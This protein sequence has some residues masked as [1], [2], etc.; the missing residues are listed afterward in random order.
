[1]LLIFGKDVV[2][3]QPQPVLRVQS[4]KCIVP[5]SQNVN[6]FE[7]NVPINGQ[8]VPTERRVERCKHQGIG[9]IA[10][11]DVVIYQIMYQATAT[12]IGF[13]AAKISLR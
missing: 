13:D 5:C 7:D 9:Y 2:E 6:I 12:A 10:D 11:A 4:K 3:R 1:M 8:Q